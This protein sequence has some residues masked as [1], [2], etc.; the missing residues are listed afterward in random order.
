VSGTRFARRA[1]IARVR[2]AV[3]VM[4]VAAVVAA[5][6]TAAGTTATAAATPA[7][8]V[9]ARHPVPKPKVSPGSQPVPKPAK[10]NDPPAVSPPKEHVNGDGKSLAATTDEIN[11]LQ[12]QLPLGPGTKNAEY[13]PPAQS[14][15][16]KAIAQAKSTGKPVEVVADRSEQNSVTANPDGTFTGQLWAGIQNVQQDGAWVKADTNLTA[17][18][19]G[20]HP[21]AVKGDLTL[22]NG[23]D[24][25]AAQFSDGAGHTV[26]LSSTGVLPTPRVSGDTAT[27][28]EVL[29]NVDLLQTALTSGVEQSLL[30]KTRPEG[31]FPTWKIPLKLDGLSAAANKTGGID[32]ADE[33]GKAVFVLGAPTAFDATGLNVVTLKQQ[34]VTNA[35][36]S[37]EIDVI[38]DQ[39]W[40]SDP[41]TKFPVT[42][43]PTG[44]PISNY[45]HT[46]V[47]SGNPTTNYSSAAYDLA[48]RNTTQTLRTFFG[49]NTTAIAGLSIHTATL[50]A[51]IH[52][53]HDPT[54]VMR[55][56]DSSGPIST[57]TNY[58]NQPPVHLL[59]DSQDGATSWQVFDAKNMMQ[60]WANAPATA[61]GTVA[62]L[63]QLEA[64]PLGG[65][66][67][68]ATL[69]GFTPEIDYTYNSAPTVPTS[70]ASSQTSTFTPKLSGTST[71]GYGQNVTSYFYVASPGSATPDIVNGSSVV[72]A[73]GSPA[74]FTLDAGLVRANTTY[75]WWM[76]S[77]VLGLCS[78]TTVHQSFTIDPLLGAGTN[79][80]FSFT[81]RQLTDQLTLKVNNATGNLVAAEK[82]I[83]LPGLT[84]DVS[85]AHTYN[86]LMNAAGST[87]LG[88]W[89][90]GYGWQMSGADERI[91]TNADGS[92]N[93]W[94]SDGSVRQFLAGSTC[95]LSAPGAFCTP[96]GV[97][98]DLAQDSSGNWTLIDHASHQTNSFDSSGFL[99]DAADRIGNKVHYDYADQGCGAYEVTTITGTRGASTGRQLHVSYTSPANGC[100]RSGLTQSDGGGYSRTVGIDQLVGGVNY[101]DPYTFTDAN[102]GVYNYNYNTGYA[103]SYVQTPNGVETYISYDSSHRVTQIEQ[104]PTGIDAITVFTYP[105]VGEVDVRDANLHTTKYF[106]DAYGRA[107]KVTDA[108]GN[109]QAGTWNGDHKLLT[110]TSAMDPTPATP[111]T[112]N[113]YAQN[114]N[115]SLTKSTSYSGAFSSAHYGPTTPAGI[116]GGAYLAD[117][118]TDTMSSQTTY[119]YN[120]QGDE[121]SSTKTPDETFKD[122]NTNTHGDTSV[123][124]T[125]RFSSEPNQKGAGNSTPSHC[126]RDVAGTVDNCT[127]YGYDSDRNLTSV[128]PPDGA[129][130]IVGQTFTYDGFGRMNTATS[131]NG[132]T[133]TYTYDNLDHTTAVA[134]SS[135][136]SNVS[137]GFDGDGNVIQ[138]I[139]G[140]GTTGFQFDNL[141][142][143]TGKN[144]GSASVTCPSTPSNSQLCYTVDKVGNLKTMSDGRGTTSYNYDAV[145]NLTSMTE[146]S[147]G[148]VDKF[149]YN[150]NNQRVQTWYKA[151]GA[152][153]AV[154]VCGT[155]FNRPATFAGHVSNCYDVDGRISSIA[156]TRA[157]SDTTYVE[158]LAYTYTLGTANTDLVQSRTDSAVGG[159]MTTYT[160]A[161]AASTG[162]GGRLASA[163]TGGGGPAYYYC[164]DGNGNIKNVW[165]SALNCATATPQHTYD[166]ANQ[167]TDTGYGTS[168]YDHDGNL[169]KSPSSTPALTSLTYNGA[170]MTSSI[171]P[172]GGSADNM[173]YTDNQGERVSQSRA[174]A[175]SYANGVGIQ[176]QTAGSGTTYFERD[177]SGA[178][179]SQVT[180]GGEYYYF[181]DNIGSV[182]ALVD[183]S[184]TQVAV[185]GY[186]PYGGHATVGAASSPNTNIANANPYRYTGTYLDSTTG[187]YKMG[188]RYY[189]PNLG[190]FTQLDPAGHL[191][192]LLQ[193]NRYGYAGDDPVN[194]TDPSGARPLEEGSYPRGEAPTTDYC[195]NSPD[196]FG[197]ASFKVACVLHDYCYQAQAGFID[198]NADLLSGMED[199]CKAAYGGWDW[200]RYACLGVAWTYWT[201]VSTAGYLAYINEPGA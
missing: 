177:P 43:D 171:T 183:T 156:G 50:K 5:G 1:R 40:L 94:F 70:L 201:A 143:Q 88:G 20:L 126:T 105:A 190:R 151:T 51:H 65:K 62:L 34:L 167:L 97:D 145:N 103:L 131:G 128:T 66:S 87:N 134:Y 108:N 33:S 14:A 125:I 29:P 118:S 92:A 113:A 182:V 27:Y 58:N 146:G 169:T 2:A 72:A 55:M 144:I 130:N 127:Y 56:Y 46:Y 175:T 79:S 119:G 13:V 193:G 68:D 6:S 181:T 178:L 153:P 187:L 76:K 139:D 157:S 80:T 160:Y 64:D 180:P 99:T 121:N 8:A 195:S 82:N 198:C 140:S 89:G 191:L 173:G 179:I 170:D 135:G 129:S 96:A 95:G 163:I 132:I 54:Y 136:A 81:S 69:S 141:N 110:T 184:G 19:D 15:D 16:A 48:G 185:Y 85:V 197:D 32:L 90:S 36:G 39:K 67:Y 21:V 138:R 196:H 147:T 49:F 71:D 166:T 189:D 86:S 59:R 93:V 37:T 25:P 100:A 174:S 114:N 152:A 186:D 98:A 109:S 112:T 63:A 17:A 18:A 12:A 52:M 24:A 9:P 91:G 176:S 107:T 137:Y 120:S 149:A 38:P 35:D 162:N 165:S 83:S 4:T 44:T 116:P 11:A 7:A 124:G 101:A 104:D 22:S 45:N 155:T 60:D 3:V 188:V 115:E 164:Y 102:G 106:S 23:G 133:T 47:D 122:Y 200:H 74:K 53:Q 75:S 142:R 10:L 57:S 117:T 172:S 111:T 26:T 192:D 158:R 42:I 77:C 150:A 194:N 78:A 28:P 161:T 30:V 61:Q 31:E 168:A 41:A 84:G 123:P 154:T 73:S 148:N 159:T 199:S